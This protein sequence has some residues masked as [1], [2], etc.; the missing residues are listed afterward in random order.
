MGKFFKPGSEPRLQDELR[1]NRP[2]PPAELVQSLAAQV[3]E[4]HPRRQG[5]FRVALAGGLTVVM[6]SG[7]ASVGGLGYAANGTKKLTKAAKRL[8]VPKKR[9]NK[10]KPL[11]LFN[12]P[13]NDQYKVFVCHRTASAQNPV[14]LISVP[15]HAALQHQQ[16]HGDF[17]FPP[18]FP[19]TPTEEDC[20]PLPPR[21][22]SDRE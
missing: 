2:E 16:Q 13:A 7:L 19:G 12:G 9:G 3:R 8:V 11:V 5:G 21:D 22:P 15:F 14:V 10:N 6:L 17:I 18:Q 1:S 4:A 20:P